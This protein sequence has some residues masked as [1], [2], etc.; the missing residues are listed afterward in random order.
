MDLESIG[1][2]VDYSRAKDVMFERT[3]IP[4]A[5]WHVVE[6]DDKKASRL[7]CIAHQRAK[8]SA[9]TRQHRAGR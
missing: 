6:S 5:R 3:D 4:E 8:R 9:R 1:R 2:Y 7:N